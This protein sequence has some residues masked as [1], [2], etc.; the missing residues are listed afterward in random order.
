M[1]TNT[2]S[3]SNQTQAERLVSFV[4]SNGYDLFHDQLG[5]GYISEA[6]RPLIAWRLRG[7]EA[8]SLLMKIAWNTFGKALRPDSLKSAILVLDGI[9]KYN[10]PKKEIYTRIAKIGSTIYYDIGDDKHVIK[11]DESG[12]VLQN[13]APVYFR[14]Y[15]HQVVQTLPERGGDIRNIKQYVHIDGITNE[16]LLT[17]YLTTCFISDIDRPLLLLY[18]PAGAGKSSTLEFVRSLIDPSRTPLLQPPKDINEMVQQANKNYAFFLD[19]VSSI[20]Q[21]ISDALCRFVTG[22]AFSKR[23]LYTDDDDILYEFKR[24][25]GFTSVAQI[26]SNADLLDR[27]LIIQLELLDEEKRISK[28]KINSDFAIE[29]PYLFG[30]LLDSVSNSLRT[31]NQFRIDKLPR[32]ADYYR[33]AVASSEYLGYGT[34]RFVEAYLSN[35]QVQKQ[36]T[37]ETSSAI[38]AILIFMKDKEYWTDTPTGLYWRLKHIAEKFEILT[39]FPKGVTGLWRKIQETKATL[40]SIGIN[41]TKNRTSKSRSITIEKTSKFN[42][43][44]SE[45]VPDINEIDERP[46]FTNDVGGKNDAVI[47]YVGERDEDNNI[48]ITKHTSYK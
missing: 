16:I 12:W 20:K 29:K 18:G 45:S 5:D 40:L 32:M 25:T 33:Y 3:H 27:S 42:K 1:K 6:E 15:A 28:E 35:T 17:T 41:I 47:S 30:S 48:V 34:E 43:T 44:I 11:I 38:Q 8:S 24:V 4:T 22:N 46:V 36:E 26:A 21:D 2:S 31:V 14:R 19:N 10:N 13:G 37:I 23:A 7:S 9:A 39:G